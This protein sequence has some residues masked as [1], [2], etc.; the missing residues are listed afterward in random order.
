MGAKEIVEMELKYSN[1]NKK[2]VSSKQQLK[3]K[4]IQRM[5]TK[6]FARDTCIWKGKKIAI[7]QKSERN[8][9]KQ[10]R[11]FLLW[12]RKKKKKSEF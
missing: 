7:C 10:P 1:K 9:G 6:N 2:K 8:K 5:G 4:D 11:S 12:S 3:T